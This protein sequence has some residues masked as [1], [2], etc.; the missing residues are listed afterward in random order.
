MRMNARLIKIQCFY[1]D[2]A[3]PVGFV[4]ITAHA[5]KSPK[6]KNVENSNFFIGPLDFN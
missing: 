2:L 5:E 4:K 3:F 1:L 6:K